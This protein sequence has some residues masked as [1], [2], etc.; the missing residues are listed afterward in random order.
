MIK[1]RY[2]FA[3]LVILF[4]FGLWGVFGSNGWS[5]DTRTYKD[6]SVAQFVKMMDHKDFTLI[7]VHIP[8]EG[9]IE[10]TDLLI[11]FNQID[12]FKNQLPADK[13]AKV[14]VYCLMG[15]MG[16]IAAERLA[17]LGYT[18]V[19]HL[20][21]GLMAWQNFGKEVL[22]RYDGRRSSRY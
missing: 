2:R 22:N 18:Q 12:R 19:M 1:M 3:S 20:Q 15:P 9:E 21:G 11:P 5:A 17:N 13:T 14:V 8:Y 7:N 16:S 4:A 10:G 6:I